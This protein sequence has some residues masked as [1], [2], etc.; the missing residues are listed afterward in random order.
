MD[1]TK[2]W[3]IPQR[4]TPDA[5]N[6]EDPPPRIVLVTPVWNDSA[7]LSQYAPAL[8][9]A[10]AASP[11]PIRWV[12]ADD[13]SD[14]GELEKLTALRTS[15]EGIF[16][17]IELLGF[18]KHRGKGAAIRG[19]WDSAKDA[20]WLAFVDADGSVPAKDILSLISAAVSCG[21]S[22]LGIRKE[23]TN[24]HIEES[25]MRGLLHRSF[26]FAVRMLLGIHCED[27]QCGAKAIRGEDYRKI[28]ADLRED[29]FA[30]D[31]EL[32]AHLASAGSTWREVPVNWTEK[33]DA[34]VRPLR[35]GAKMLV[36]LF[37]I[38]QRISAQPP[39]PKTSTSV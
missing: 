25:M 34:K 10:L 15:L 27:P 1:T 38:R 8:A 28:R 16:P 7:R 33:G 9:A 23:T 18:S 20:E 29:G 35:D 3:D 13:G 12:I 30:F 22:M 39:F 6:P 14:G 24:T 37:R 4:K 26:I 36:S 21:E 32:L 19:A 2:G 5:L 17:H 31:S 11:L